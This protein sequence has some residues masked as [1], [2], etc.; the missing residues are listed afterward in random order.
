MKATGKTVV[1]SCCVA[2]VCVIVGW[3]SYRYWANSQRL[4]EAAKA[5]QLQ[6]SRGDAK[7]EYELS[8]MYFYGNGVRRNYVEAFRLAHMAADQGFATADGAIGSSYYYGLGV[9][10]D[11]SE[12]FRCTASRRPKETRRASTVSATCIAVAL[13]SSRMISRL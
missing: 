11:Y 8:K 9:P 1:W 4:S 2:L 6:A 12:A 13:A 7:A 3:R 5:C 10:K